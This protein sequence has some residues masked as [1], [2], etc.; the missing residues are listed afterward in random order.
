[1]HLYP[2]VARLRWRGHI[3]LT[4]EGNK[5]H[6]VKANW[7]QLRGQEEVEWHECDHDARPNVGELRPAAKLTFIVSLTSFE[8][9]LN[10]SDNIRIMQMMEFHIDVFSV[11]VD[12]LN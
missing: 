2:G 3:V 12:Q 8:I 5:R 4:S 7:R 1:M 10:Y 9:S 6:L 11:D